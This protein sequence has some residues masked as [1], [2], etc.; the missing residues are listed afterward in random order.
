[1]NN[2][3]LIRRHGMMMGKDLPYDAK[4]Q[5]LESTGTQYLDI[6]AFT[7]PASVSCVQSTKMR[8]TQS[9]SS[10]ELTGMNGVFWFGKSTTDKWSCNGY[11]TGSG[12]ALSLSVVELN[13]APQGSRVYFYV[14]G[15]SLHNFTRGNTSYPDMH[16]YVFA[17]GESSNLFYCNAQIYNYQL[18]I[19]NALAFDGIP[20][21]V[22]SVGY[23]YDRVSGQL[24][25]NAGTGAF[26]LGPDVI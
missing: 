6:G 23:M 4:I 16:F 10:R 19:D 11:A 9:N 26:V 21:R 1:M 13:A 14:N 3:L 25:G 8:Y 15:S 24:F 20:V 2:A 12:D 5:Y 18:S 22:G 17:L 7:V